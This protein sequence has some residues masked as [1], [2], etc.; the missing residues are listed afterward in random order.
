M[1]DAQNPNSNGSFLRDPRYARHET[2][3]R[4]LEAIL[5]THSDERAMSTLRGHFAGLTLRTTTATTAHAAFY[6]THGLIRSWA[7]TTTTLRM[8]LKPRTLA[9]DCATL[10]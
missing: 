1:T 10:D 8:Q 6:A 4:T 5:C 3:K 9:R 7:T 2:T